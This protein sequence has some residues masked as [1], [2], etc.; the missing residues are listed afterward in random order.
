MELF[1]QNAHLRVARIITRARGATSSK[2]NAR[3]SKQK[4]THNNKS[5][6]NLYII[7]NLSWLERLYVEDAVAGF[8]RAWEVPAADGDAATAS[9]FRF[10]PNPAFTTSSSS[11]SSGGGKAPS[12]GG[13][14]RELLR[15]EGARGLWRG[16]APRIASSSVFGVAMTV[17]YQSL[18]RWCALPE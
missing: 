18:K 3:S 14:L 8:D 2:L 17:T 12:W 7:S 10:V 9:G 1:A 15:E 5:N 6:T 16:L 11:S 13:I 4:H